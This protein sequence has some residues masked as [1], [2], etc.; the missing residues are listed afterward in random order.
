V[1][2]ALTRLAGNGRSMEGNDRFIEGSGRGFIRKA[3]RC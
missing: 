3:D 1:G 2:R